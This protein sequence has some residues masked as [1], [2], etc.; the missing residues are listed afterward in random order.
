[1]NEMEQATTDEENLEGTV[2]SGTPPTIATASNLTNRATAFLAVTPRFDVVAIMPYIYVAVMAAALFMLEQAL[3]TGPDRV[4]IRATAVLPLALVA[5]GQ[6]LVIFTRGIDLSVGGVISLTNCILATH[7]QYTGGALILE[8]VIIVLLGAALGSLNGIIIATT[9]LQ[10]F[11]VT[12]ATWSIWDGAA[13]K[14][15]PVEGGLPPTQLNDLAGGFQITVFETG[16]HLTIPK[17][18]LG[19]VAL[20]L[21]WFWLKDTRFIQ[22]LRAIGSD[23]ARSRLTGVPLIRR[24]VQVYMLSGALAGLAGIYW[25]YS[26]ATGNPTSGDQFILTSVAAVVVG[27]ASIFGGVGSGART[28]VGAIALLM[29]PDVIFAL[30]LQSFWSTVFQGLLLILAVTISSIILQVRAAR[31]A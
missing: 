16:F 24:R 23:E 27:G 9:R 25:T 8:L 29:I 28:I 31:A 1:M 11:I 5:M 4:D 14:V 22:D 7:G 15:L 13:L 3:L 12:L 17:S 20:L 10:P 21:L 2:D 26:T 30:N 6:T 18:V 19:L